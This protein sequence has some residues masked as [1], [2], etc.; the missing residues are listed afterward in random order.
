MHQS[1]QGTTFHVEHVI[2][3]SRSGL[4]ELDNLAWACPRC[5]LHE[6]NRTDV[7]D[8]DTGDQVLLSNPRIDDWDGHFR[9]DDYRIV[10]QTTIGRV[11]A[12]ALELNHPRRVQI[13]QAEKLFDLFPPNEVGR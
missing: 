4:S 13:R 10:G 9:W 7:I 3:R 5:N 6:A 12:A 8:P 1:L 11:T 2:P